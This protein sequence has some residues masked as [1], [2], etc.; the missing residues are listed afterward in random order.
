[1]LR[2]YA[3]ACMQ[4]GTQANMQGTDAD[5]LGAIVAAIALVIILLISLAVDNRRAYRA[6][7]QDHW[8]RA[9]RLAKLHKQNQAWLK[10]N[11]YGK[12]RHQPKE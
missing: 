12:Y 7:K 4:L 10:A 6:W 9:E 3:A 1:M 5:Y 8:R 11:G 2:D